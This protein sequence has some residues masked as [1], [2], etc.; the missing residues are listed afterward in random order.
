MLVLIAA[1]GAVVAGL[2]AAGHRR[3]RIF[4]LFAGGILFGVGIFTADRVDFQTHVAKGS[5]KPGES[6]QRA[7]YSR[8]DPAAKIDVMP[9]PCRSCGGSPTTAEPSAHPITSSTAISAT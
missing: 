4:T 1:A 2:L 3:A 8:W 9:T 6:V 7:E 5:L